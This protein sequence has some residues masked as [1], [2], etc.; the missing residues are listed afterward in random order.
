[1]IFWKSSLIYLALAGASDIKTSEKKGFKEGVFGR[2]ISKRLLL[3]GM[4]VFKLERLLDIVKQSGFLQ[5]NII[6]I[7]FAN[8]KV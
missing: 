8:Y 6:V 2:K 3:V 1:M 4:E 7:E 5:K